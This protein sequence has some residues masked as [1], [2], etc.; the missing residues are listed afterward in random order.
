MPLKALKTLA[1]MFIQ[2][3]KLT[4]AVAEVFFQIKFCLSGH[5]GRKLLMCLFGWF[6]YNFLIRLTSINCF[7]VLLTAI[8]PVKTAFLAGSSD[9][10]L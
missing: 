10:R 7:L 8:Y 1:S 2:A 9:L 5:L 4:G 3:I 6:K